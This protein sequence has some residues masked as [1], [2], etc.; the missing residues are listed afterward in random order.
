LPIAS[1]KSGYRLL[2]VDTDWAEMGRLLIRARGAAKPEGLVL[3]REALA[4]TRGLPFTADTTRYFTWTFTSSVLY[5]IVETTTA[6]AHG[7]A[8]DLVL[9]GDLA[10][11]KGALDQG[12]LVDPASL[13]LWEDLTDVLLETAD[14]SLLALHW[15]AAELVLR[16]E[17]IVLLR[18]REHG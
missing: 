13:T 2:R 9:A 15:K 16:P 12:L 1:G 14:Q 7:V 11:A 8:T 18:N 5:K 6:L 17:D 10:G 4:L 3:R